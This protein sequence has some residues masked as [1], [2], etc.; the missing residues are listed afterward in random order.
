MPKKLTQ[1]ETAITTL[2]FAGMQSIKDTPSVLTM[3]CISA[4]SIGQRTCAARRQTLTVLTGPGLPNLAILFD[5][6]RFG[7]VFGR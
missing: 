6:N 3:P 2:P 1:L 4:R 5:N 7:I